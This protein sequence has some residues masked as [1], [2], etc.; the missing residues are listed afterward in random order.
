MKTQQAK[1]GEIRCHLGPQ[2]TQT[3]KKRDQ[4]SYKWITMWKKEIEKL[5]RTINT[6]LH[7]GCFLTT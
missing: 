3:K 6:R 5:I 4:D 1:D 2:T 7:E